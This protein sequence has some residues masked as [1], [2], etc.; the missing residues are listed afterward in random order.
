MGNQFTDNGDYPAC[1]VLLKE[2][3]ESPW[4]RRNR[5]L[6]GAT[7]F[8]LAASA[9]GI[10][11]AAA[12]WTIA[13]SED[14]GT[15]WNEVETPHLGPWALATLPDGTLLANGVYRSTDR[16]RTW[17]TSL[18]APT[19]VTQMTVS[20]QGVVYAGAYYGTVWQS[21]DRGASWSLIYGP[22]S[23]LEPLVS[24]ASGPMSRIAFSTSTETVVFDIGAGSSWILPATG[25]LA[26]AHDERAIYVA[27]GNAVQRWVQESVGWVQQTMPRFPAEEVAVGPEGRVYAATRQSV[28]WTV[29]GDSAWHELGS[30][31]SR[32][33]LD[34]KPR[35]VF[36]HDGY[37][38]FGTSCHG[39]YRSATPV[40]APTSV[41]DFDGLTLL[42]WGC[43]P[44]P[45]R[46]STTLSFGLAR[47]SP[48]QVSVYDVRGRLVAMLADDRLFDSGLHTLQWIPSL[49]T[50]SGVYTYR[51][52]AGNVVRGGR[53]VLVR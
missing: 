45:A 9:A 8:D 50:P 15:S 29:P 23:Y 48:V 36:A 32:W 6:G 31:C 10:V 4:V 7:I 20:P 27:D 18:T 46:G 26:F 25:R 13:W 12:D 3:D 42:A 53:I 34:Q 49:G 1:G 39:V 37:L 33:Y 16:G 11:Y 30:T 35:L 17:E 28:A 52:R 22:T 14:D 44:N 19:G 51:I 40:R 5:G 24:I 38:Y 41:N 2:D 21:T 47:S 43:T